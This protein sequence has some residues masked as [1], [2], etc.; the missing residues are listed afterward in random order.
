MSSRMRIA[1]GR[2]LT[3]REAAEDEE[4]E[5]ASKW[6]EKQGKGV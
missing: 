5:G 1:T 6:A 2:R 3:V 4:R